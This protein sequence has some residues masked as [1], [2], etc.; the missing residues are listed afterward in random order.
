MH[1]VF[2]SDEPPSIIQRNH[3]TVIAQGAVI[4]VGVGVDIVVVTTSVDHHDC[5][6]V[7]I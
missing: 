2:V 3:L 5:K 1:I 4:V 7:F 6:A